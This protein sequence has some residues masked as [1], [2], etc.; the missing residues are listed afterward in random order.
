[1]DR[2][3]GG[4]PPSLPD[5]RAYPNVGGDNRTG[6]DMASMTSAT[7]PADRLAIEWGPRALSA[8]RIVVALLFMEHGTAKLLVFP[9]SDATAN[10]PLM[11]LIGLSGIL[12]GVGGL[13]LL[14]GLFTRPVAFVLSGEMAVAYFMVHFPHAFFPML[15]GGDAAVLYCF[16]FLYFVVAGGGCWSID[17]MRAG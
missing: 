14:L 15:N 9:F 16:V 12:E 1:V 4:A 3:R 11:S 5:G 8:L 6:D 17:R 10:V 13:L 2:R 7:G